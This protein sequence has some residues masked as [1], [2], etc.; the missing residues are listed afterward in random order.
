MMTI[1]KIYH[2]F[3]AKASGLVFRDLLLCGCTVFLDIDQNLRGALCG[4]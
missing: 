3:K 4:Y 1:D 2:T